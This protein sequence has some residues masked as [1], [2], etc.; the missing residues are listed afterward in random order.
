VSDDPPALCAEAV[1]VAFGGVLALD[2]VWV[3]VG[4]REI[5]GLLG[6]NGAGKTSLLNVVSGLLR[7][8]SGRIRLFGRDISSLRPEHRARLGLG[9]TFQDG[10]LFPGLTLRESVQLGLARSRPAGFCG[11]LLG[12][13]WSRETERGHGQ[14]ADEVI[15]RFAL[16]PWADSLLA[17][18]STGTRRACDLAVQAATGARLLLLDEPTAGLAQRETESFA[19]LLRQ[20]RDDLGC[21][22]LLVEH[23]IPFIMD[24]ADRLYAMEGARVIADGPPSRIHADPAVL[25]SYLGGTGGQSARLRVGRP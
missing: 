24:V 23:D 15:E 12:A 20:V 11:S 14:R 7:P 10:R 1:T 13:P 25:A 9:R 6:T 2:D 18:L 4:D 21:A 3:E 19:R 22:I 16:G 17:H 5:V 8:S